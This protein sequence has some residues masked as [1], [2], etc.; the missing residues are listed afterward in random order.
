MQ[1]AFDLE[2]DTYASLYALGADAFRV[3]ARLGAMTGGGPTRVLGS[4]GV[5]T[6]GE[7]GRMARELD[8]ARVQNRAVRRWNP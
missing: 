3:S 6:L 4:T 5:L 7:D 8:W 1:G 2:T